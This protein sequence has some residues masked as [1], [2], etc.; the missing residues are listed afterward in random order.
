MNISVL[1]LLCSL[2]KLL[3]MCSNM[4]YWD[5]F[6]GHSNKVHYRRTT[7]APF[8]GGRSTAGLTNALKHY[9]AGEG[10]EA[11]RLIK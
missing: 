5:R 4:P 9:W 3:H 2:L 7:H 11:V 6:V 1:Y 10:G 8:A